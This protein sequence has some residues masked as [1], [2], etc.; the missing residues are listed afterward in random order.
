M[1]DITIQLPQGEGARLV[2]LGH[3]LDDGRLMTARPEGAHRAVA[4][5]T[6]LIDLRVPIRRPSL[7]AL[8]RYPTMDRV[9]DSLA[10]AIRPF[11]LSF[12]DYSDFNGASLFGWSGSVD[13]GYR[14]ASLGENLVVEFSD[15]LTDSR[16]L[17]FLGTD[18]VDKAAEELIAGSKK[19]GMNA[20]LHLVPEITAARLDPRCWDVSEDRDSADY[21]YAV[22]DVA[23]L[24]GKPY[25]SLRYS[26][27]AWQRRWS[28]QAEL[29]WMDLDDL[30]GHSPRALELLGNWQ[31]RGS[32]GAS[33]A[34]Q[35]FRALRHIL[36]SSA[37]VA[38]GISGWSG[39]CLVEGEMAAFFVNEREDF[40]RLSGHFL[41][42]TDQPFGDR[43]Y[44]WF[45]VELCRKAHEA[46]IT[47]LNLQQDLGI[48]GLRRTKKQ[49]RPSRMLRKY[50]VRPR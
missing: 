3:R 14:V 1:S 34:E 33:Q 2:D 31:Q 30:R 28:D 22:A 45:F 17:S 13:G 47:H 12:D 29:I 24:S 49:L 16:F 21:V 48:E 37:R 6:D 35:E 25:R 19:L 50:T 5:K 18:G 23:A 4:P 26:H 9:D 27:N 36:T 20:E 15:Y 32:E 43:F 46:G 38:P 41:K 11:V 42:M 10:L 7:S 44:S 8:P 40:H 39:M